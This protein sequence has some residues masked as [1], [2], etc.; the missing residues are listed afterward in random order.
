MCN[1]IRLRLLPRSFWSD[2]DLA[3]DQGVNSKVYDPYKEYDALVKKRTAELK[4]MKSSPRSDKEKEKEKKTKGKKGGEKADKSELVEETEDDAIAAVTP[5]TR[6]SFGE[7]DFDEMT[8]HHKEVLERSCESR[9]DF[10]R[11]KL[12]PGDPGV[13][14]SVEEL[15]TTVARHVCH[16]CLSS[17]GDQTIY[18]TDNMTITIIL[19]TNSKLGRA[20]LKCHPRPEGSPTPSKT[21]STHRTRTRER[22][23]H[24]VGDV[25]LPS[26]FEGSS[27]G[28]AGAAAVVKPSAVVTSSKRSTCS[29]DGSPAKKSSHKKH[30]K[31]RQKV[32]LT[33][34]MTDAEKMVYQFADE[35]SG[36]EKY[37]VAPP[38]P[39]IALK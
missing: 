23:S 16:N 19:F 27:S 14:S 11:Y 35:F 12:W 30:T 32:D 22:R 36:D 21:E 9:E 29:T 10:E 6:R 38:M 17:D 2:E 20:V 26:E 18:G 28:S 34:P 3:I 24:S 13:C 1:F 7:E 37:V 5:T 15:L 33:A 8:K 39:D 4:A 25:D 31:R